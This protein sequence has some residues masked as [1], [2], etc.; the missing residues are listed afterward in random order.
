MPQVR[1]SVP[2]PKTKGALAPTIAFAESLEAPVA[3]LWCFVQGTIL[4]A[5]EEVGLRRKTVPSVAKQPA[6]NVTRRARLL[7][8]P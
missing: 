8:V 2:G 1:Q 4:E 5:A 6:E 7:A 3:R